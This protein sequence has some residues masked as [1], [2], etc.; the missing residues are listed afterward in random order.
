MKFRL[1][2]FFIAFHIN[3]LQNKSF[4]TK[5][6]NH[7]CLLTDGIITSC[8][9]MQACMLIQGERGDMHRSQFHHH[10]LQVDAI[11]CPT[12]DLALPRQQ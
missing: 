7:G 6:S 4:A 12:F 5:T 8:S 3:C 2:F 10:R 1:L 9:V 11:S